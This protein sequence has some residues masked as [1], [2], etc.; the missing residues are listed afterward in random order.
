MGAQIINFRPTG[1]HQW[2][3]QAACTGVDMFPGD[4]DT[5]AIREAKS[6]C[7]GCPVRFECLTAALENGEVHGVWGGLDGNELATIR[8]VDARRARDN[9]RDRTAAKDMAADALDAEATRL[10]AEAAEQARLSEAERAEADRKAKRAEAMADAANFGA[11]LD[12]ASAHVDR[13][14]YG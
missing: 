1:E 9:G 7:Q 3:L 13:V 12:A 10:E 6:L 8:R 5:R 4:G 14:V 2:T 11:M